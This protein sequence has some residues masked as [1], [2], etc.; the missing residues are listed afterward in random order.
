MKAPLSLAAMLTIVAGLAFGSDALAQSTGTGGGSGPGTTATPPPIKNHGTEIDLPIG[1]PDPAGELPPD[2]PVEDDPPPAEDDPPKL[3]DEDIPTKTQSIWYVID[4][5]GSMGWDSQ[6]YTGLD[7]QTRTGDRLDR[8][9][10]ELVK[11]IQGLSRDF[12]FNIIAYDCDLRRWSPSKQRAEPGPKAQAIAWTMNL[13][14]LGAT[15]TGP[16]TAAALGD[17]NNFTVVLLSDGAPNCGASS[18]NGHLRMIQGANTQGAAIH[19]FG[20]AC[21]GEFERFMRDVA[22]TSGG[23]YHPVP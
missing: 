10:V 20:I 6:S 23:R 8:A 18:T 5:S 9:K 16:A 12:E 4:I 21:Y 19:T 15:G 2:P 14:P 17:K 7:G 13:Q 1:T 3:Y 22:T 11:S